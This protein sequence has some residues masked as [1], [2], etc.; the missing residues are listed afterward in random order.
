MAGN[1]IY[2]AAPVFSLAERLFNRRLARAIQDRL[3]G[4]RVFLPQDCRVGE[5]ESFN[6]RRHS[7]ALYE[8]CRTTVMSNEELEAI[9]M[10]ELSK[11]AK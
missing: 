6:D 4:L 3:P 11:A 1:T 2:L 9:A 8:A 10:D 7:R 5:F